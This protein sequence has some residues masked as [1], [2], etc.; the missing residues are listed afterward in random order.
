MKDDK[1]KPDQRFLSK[2]LRCSVSVSVLSVRKQLDIKQ[3]CRNKSH[4]FTICDMRLSEMSLKLVKFNFD[5]S[6][7]LYTLQ[8]YFLQQTPTEIDQLVPKIWAV[9]GLQKQQKTKKLSALFGYILK[10]LFASFDSFCLI[11][12]L[13]LDITAH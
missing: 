3:N 10:Q 4:F 9:E 11:T 7:Y 6:Y 1:W 5:F 13:V 12:S 8:S 2:F